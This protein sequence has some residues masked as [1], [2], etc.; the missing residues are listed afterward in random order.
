M[1]PLTGIRII[2]LAGLGPVPFAAMLL[3]DLGAEV[4]RID[5][6][7]GGAIQ[8]LSRVTC[9]SRRSVGVDLKD[10]SGQEVLLDLIE[11]ADVFLEGLRPGVAERL[12]VGPQACLGRQ[13]ELVYG[14]MTGWGREGPMAPM[15]GHDI[16]YIALTGALDAIG[17]AGSDPT[18]P[19][20]L[21]GDYGGGALYLAMGVL[22]AVVERQR[23][24]QGQVVDAAMID[25]AASLMTM[26]Y[27][28]SAMGMWS[29]ERG[30]NLLDGGA[31]FYTT[32]PTADGGWMAV[33]AL[34]PQFFA[35]LVAKLDLRGYDVAEQYDRS[36][37]P[38]LDELLRR[39]FGSRTKAELTELFAGSDAC[40]VPVLSM[41]EAPQHPHNR[42][43]GVFVD[44]AGV[45]QAAPAPRFSRTAA[46]D[47]TPAPSPGADTDEV[48]GELGLGHDRIADL[49]NSGAIF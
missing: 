37:W 19:L 5:R 27:E 4:I 21:V 48:L 40:V 8:G 15:A 9:R 31:P 23:S 39:A 3:G 33:G 43:R 11:S 12:G 30:T 47:P 34:E 32:Y 17:S 41:A 25:G 26:F 38:R 13:P 29:P 14:R 18:P 46:P 44:V 7:G 1:G 2:E 28:F 10:P 36:S 42:E 16:N 45:I 49:R 6:P 24:G 20:N 22:A 35:E